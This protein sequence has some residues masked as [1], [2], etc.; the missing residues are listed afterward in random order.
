MHDET[1]ER[2][3]A[4]QTEVYGEP[5]G[6]LVARVRERL[7]LTQRRVASVLGLSPAMLS[8]LVT[9]QRVKIGNPAV[10]SRFTDLLELAASDPVPAGAALE[11]RLERIQA[12]TRR[13]ST[14]TSARAAG[15]E[16]LPAQLRLL[17]SRAEL[18]AAAGLVAAEVP[19]LAAVLRQAADG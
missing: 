9:G 12:E 1:I 4:Q 7:G 5:A 18:R 15:N 19:A 14:V 17:A 13:L 8:Q 3:L 16:S 6:V 2:N 11:E 10:V